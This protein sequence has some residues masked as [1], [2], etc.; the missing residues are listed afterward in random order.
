MEIT[1]TDT[2][3]FFLTAG[4]IA[5]LSVL[6]AREDSPGFPVTVAGAKNIATIVFASDQVKKKSSDTAAWQDVRP[7]DLVQESDTLATGAGARIRLR[8]FDGQTLLLGENQLAMI[9]DAKNQEDF[10]YFYNT[11]I[12]PTSKNKKPASVKPTY[13]PQ[14]PEPVTVPEETKPNPSKT[15]TDDFQPAEKLIVPVLIHPALNAAIDMTNKDSLAFNWQEIP[16]VLGYEFTLYKKKGG[17]QALILSMQTKDTEFLLKDLYKL[18]IAHFSW[19]L[20]GLYQGAAG[21]EKS[22]VARSY[23]TVTLDDKKPKKLEILTPD[24]IFVP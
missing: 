11:G 6:I 14:K 2:I 12:Q 13:A 9:T 8:F 23:F 3:I 4:L 19:T 24:I 7:G 18:D 22:P 15:T 21:I 16:G 1:R 10:I 20:R 5:V 17:A